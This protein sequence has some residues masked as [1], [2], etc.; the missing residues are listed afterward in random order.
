[1]E[2]KIL[3]DKMFYRDVRGIIE[4]FLF[5]KC[6]RCDE[7]TLVEE[8]LESIRGGFYCKRCFLSPMIRN[9][10]SCDRLYNINNS[11]I[12]CFICVSNFCRLYCNFCYVRKRT[13]LI[14]AEITDV[15]HLDLYWILD[16][17]VNLIDGLLSDYE[18]DI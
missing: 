14:T 5:V 15:P 11:E 4:S 13:E 16:M 17:S 1:M 12:S 6:V 8:H 10:V 7:E 3:L 9:C 18:L 2:V